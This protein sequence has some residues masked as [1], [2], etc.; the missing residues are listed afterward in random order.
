M[1][2]LGSRESETRK[3]EKLMQGHVIQVVTV[4][5]GAQI[6][7][8]LLRS[9]QTPRPHNCPAALVFHLSKVAWDR[10]LTPPYFRAAYA[11]GPLPL[12]KDS[13]VRLS[14]VS[15]SLRRHPC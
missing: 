13:G 12:D 11:Q 1:Q 14:A 8:Q 6:C 10:V 3:K 15:G 2:N 4:V 7:Q 9:M 5:T